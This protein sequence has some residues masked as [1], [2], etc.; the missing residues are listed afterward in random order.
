MQ[1][2]RLNP[3]RALAARGRDRRSSSHRQPPPRP[4][5]ADLRVEGAGKPLAAA[6]YVTDTARSR[7]PRAPR[8]KGS[9]DVKTVQG[10]TALGLLW[11]APPDQ[12]APA[13]GRQR[14][15]RLRPARLRDLELR[16][17][18]HRLLALQGRP[19][20]PEVGAD[21]FPLKGGEE[22]LWYFS[23]TDG[24]RE[25][26]RR[27]GAPGAGEGQAGQ[28]RRGPRLGLRRGRQAHAGRGRRGAGRGRGDH[29]RPGA[30]HRR[31]PGKGHAAACGPSAAPTSRRDRC[32]C[33]S[34]PSG[35]LRVAPRASRSSAPPRPTASPAPRGRTRLAGAGADRV[36]VRGGGTDT[37]RCGKGRDRVSADRRRPR[38]ARLRGRE[39]RMSP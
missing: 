2:S 1:A 12:V 38:G 23:D 3:G 25:H 31:H 22:V 20:V 4:E 15:V 18:R 6:S 17:R 10:A 36:S 30:G 11:S 32:R 21:Q 37:V 34:P 29:R 28:H 35:E 5:Q 13:A 26:R 8:C 16:G 9:G 33:A 14:R 27:A 19:Q 7:P 24:E 39:A